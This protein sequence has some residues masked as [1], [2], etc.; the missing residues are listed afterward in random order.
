[1]RFLSLCLLAASLLLCYP[2]DAHHDGYV[3]VARDKTVTVE[4]V[5]EEFQFVDP[6]VVLIV[7]TDDSTVV[8]A[9]WMTMWQL[10]NGWG[11]TQQILRQG[12]RVVVRGSPYECE[13][14]RISLLTEVR[15][16]DDGWSWQRG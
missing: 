7:R 16:L 4:G 9:E 11:I 13:E 3:C 5:I 12:D 14:N 15:R 10:S 1:M 2:V 8:T 6:H